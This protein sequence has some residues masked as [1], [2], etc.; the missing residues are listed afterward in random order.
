MAEALDRIHIRE[1]RLRCILG[2]RDWERRKKQEIAIDLTLHADL[3][4]AC[5]SDAI[6]DTVDYS[7]LKQRVIELVEASAFQLVERLAEAVADLC[8]EDGRVRRVEVTIDKAGA[9]RFARSV[10]VSITRERTGGE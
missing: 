8:L 10:A 9:L 7:T 3:R 6:D 2:L 1:L 5:R 4:A